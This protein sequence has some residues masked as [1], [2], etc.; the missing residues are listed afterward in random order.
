MRTARTASSKRDTDKFAEAICAFANDLADRRVPGVLFIGA[1]DDGSCAGLEIDDEFL[2]SLTDFR[3]DGRILPP[4][5][6]AVSKKRLGGCELAV[7]EVAPS[8][9]PLVKFKG[10]THIRVGP[11]RGTA[12]AEEEKRLVEK[13]RLQNLPFDQQPVPGGL[14]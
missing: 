14:P 8:H 3:S 12:T 5:V 9:N 10:R 6:M 7:V 13:R 4:P 1:N 2:R 11:R